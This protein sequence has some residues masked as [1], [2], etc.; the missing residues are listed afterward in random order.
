MA[1]L[2]SHCPACGTKLDITELHCA[3]C[4]MDLR[5]D[6]ELSLFDLL[7]A[8]QKEFLLSFLRQRGNMSAVQRELGVSYPTASKRLDQLL[9][10][11]NLAEEAKNLPES[12]KGM[13]LP[14][15]QIP[16]DSVK[17]SDI[18][19][20]KLIDHNGSAIVQTARG[21]PCDIR[22]ALD[23]I[24]FVS[25][26]LPVKPPYRYEV[27]DVIVELL[28]AQKGRARKGNGRSSKLGEPNCDETTVVGAIGYHYT[29]AQNGQSVYDPVFVLAAVLEW[30][31][32]V[33]NERGELALTAEYLEKRQIKNL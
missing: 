25:S 21:V 14:N 31:G 3:G 29:H 32:V 2:I 15:W 9:S 6:F 12:E 13:N 10:A 16:K 33:H 1:K 26:K 18:V 28:I 20:Q 17:A 8:E 4:G 27:F 22:A 24:S 23:G 30:A 19:K 5:N 7:D 11:L